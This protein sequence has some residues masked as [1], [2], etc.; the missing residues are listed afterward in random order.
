ML[1]CSSNFI[2]RPL[3]ILILNAAVFAPSEKST[4]DGY[5]RAFGVNYLGHFYLTYL[6]LPRIRESTPARIVIVSSTSHNHT[7]VSLSTS[8]TFWVIDCRKSTCY[9]WLIEKKRVNGRVGTK[10]YSVVIMFS[11]ERI[12]LLSIYEQ[13]G[14]SLKRCLSAI[15]FE[16]Q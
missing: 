12:H 15:F 14:C 6:L 7:G 10:R 9:C 13:G 1:L 16:K 4:I 2:L 3:H 5:E 11:W 8:C